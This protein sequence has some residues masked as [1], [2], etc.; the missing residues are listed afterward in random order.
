MKRTPL[1]RKTP[2]RRSR[3]GFKAFQ[4]TLEALAPRFRRRKRA[5]TPEERAHLAFVK[6]QPCIAC[7]SKGW[8]QGTVTVVHHVRE[9]N[10]MGQ[11]ASHFDTLPICWHHHASDS[12][13]G[14]HAHPAWWISEFG[15]E[16]DLLAQ[17]KKEH[18]IER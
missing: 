3:V 10:G 14:F 13:D 17:F 5:A 1:L 2:M 15:T 8:T 6:S 12:R 7:Q 4:R 16:R 11:R 9:G 18:G